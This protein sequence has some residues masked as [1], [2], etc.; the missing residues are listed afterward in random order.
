MMSDNGNNTGSAS[1]SLEAANKE[2][3]RRYFREVLDG[4]RID[5]M[6]ELIRADAVLHR[7]GLDVVGLDAAMK[8]LEATLA[9]FTSFLSEVEG[10]IAEGDRVCVRITHR[11]RVRP[12]TFRS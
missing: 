2:I 1:P 12:H 5:L 10:V 4:K 8:R 11:T 7:P 3:V 9:Q 6:P